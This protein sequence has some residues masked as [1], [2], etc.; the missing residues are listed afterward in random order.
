MR[1]EKRGTGKQHSQVFKTT[2]QRFSNTRP[3]L[4]CADTAPPPFPRHLQPPF[5][6]Y[7][8]FTYQLPLIFPFPLLFLLF[9]PFL[10]PSRIP[11]G[12]YEHSFTLLFLIPE[13][14]LFTH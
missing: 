5:H 2:S 6:S 14:I 8:A 1:P 9:H 12:C 11:A 3:F 10:I 13:S 4:R 7:F